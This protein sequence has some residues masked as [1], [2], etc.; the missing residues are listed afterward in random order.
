MPTQVAYLPTHL[1]D[2]YIYIRYNIY[3][4]PVKE[5]L[6]VNEMPQDLNRWLGAIFFLGWHIKVVHKRNNVFTNRR[7]VD[8]IPTAGT[9]KRYIVD[10]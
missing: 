5:V 8:T 6:M 7:P 10:V 1:I 9:K 2:I 4:V 3:T